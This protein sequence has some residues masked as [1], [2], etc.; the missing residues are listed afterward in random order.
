MRGGGGT[1]STSGSPVAV[2]V[3]NSEQYSV[4]LFRMSCSF[5]RHF[6]AL[7]WMVV[8]LLCLELVG[9]FTSW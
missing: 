8:V 1:S 7:S 2:R 3:Y 4:H 9:Y 6:H 5:V